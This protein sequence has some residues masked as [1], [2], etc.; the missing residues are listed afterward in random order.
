MVVSSDS[1]QADTNSENSYFFFFIYIKLIRLTGGYI[2]GWR[3]AV[4]E[5]VGESVESA[6]GH[7]P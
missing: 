6:T 3:A 2:F 5:G 7:K 4:K 1:Q